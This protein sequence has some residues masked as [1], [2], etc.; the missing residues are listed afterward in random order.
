MLFIILYINNVTARTTERCR[1]RKQIRGAAALVKRE[2]DREGGGR[3]IAAISLTPA[4][5][6]G[7]GGRPR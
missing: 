7:E 6:I 1:Q 4:I 5:C 2:R 3:R